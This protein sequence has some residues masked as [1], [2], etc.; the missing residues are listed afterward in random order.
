MLT[1]LLSAFN[2]SQNPFFWQTL[3]T[4]HKLKLQGFEINPIVGVTPGRD[5]TISRLERAKIPFV[6]VLSSK[7]AD[8][9]NRAFEL[10]SCKKDDWIIL[11]HPRSCLE[12]NAFL[13]LDKLSPFHKWGAFTH[14][15][16]LEHPLL[17]FT[18]WW[19]NHVRGDL[20]Q[21]YY[22]DHCLFV[23]REVLE[24]A[25]GF[26]DREIFEDTIL[27]QKLSTHHTPI[28]LPFKSTTSAVRF[29]TN[30]IWKQAFKNQALKFRY[31]LKHDDYEMN[32]E[33]ERGLSL[34][35]EGS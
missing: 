5:D 18:S 28:R 15:F 16:D 32:R 31:H 6:E 3:D 14:Q 19:S 30:G 4:V 29:Q 24:K 26:P 22:L 10:A 34:N 35:T 12:I 17:S 8:R 21:I 11:N 25:G 23:R 1:I 20:K 7:R 27:S 9:Y 2:E 13:S 33:Y